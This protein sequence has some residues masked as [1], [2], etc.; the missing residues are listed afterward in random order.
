M[1]PYNATHDITEKDLVYLR[2]HRLKCEAAQRIAEHK[3]K[4]VYGVHYRLYQL[5]NVLDCIPCF[6]TELI[7]VWIRSYLFN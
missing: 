5:C 3:V 4:P 6:P 7:T 1:T 2:W